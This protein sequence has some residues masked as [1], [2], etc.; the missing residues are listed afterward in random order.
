MFTFEFVFSIP[1]K[2]GWRRE[3]ASGKDAYA[4]LDN[5]RYLHGENIKVHQTTCL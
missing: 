3:T 1:G 5:L 2:P 4:A